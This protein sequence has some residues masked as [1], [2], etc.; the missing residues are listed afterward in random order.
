MKIIKIKLFPRE[1]IESKT[2]AYTLRH[3]ATMVSINKFKHFTSEYFTFVTEYNKKNIVSR[4]AGA[5]SVCRLVVGSIPT[6]E[7]I[8]FT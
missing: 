7:D 3:S 8:I 6:R 1:Y 4:S 2:V 5:Q